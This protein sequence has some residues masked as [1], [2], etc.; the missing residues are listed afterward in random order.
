[1]IKITDVAGKE[2][3]INSD[4]IERIELIPD[5]L[6][7]LSNGNN[8][9]VKDKPEEIVDKIINFRARCNTSARPELSVIHKTDCE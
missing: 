3:Y 7:T 4:M 2:K 5:T 9:I 8:I 6:L 1:M